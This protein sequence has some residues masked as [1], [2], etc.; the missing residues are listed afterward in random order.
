LQIVRDWVLRFNAKGPH[1]LFN[2]KAPGAPSILHDSQRDAVRQ[3][4]EDGP[5]KS[6]LGEFEQGDKWSF[7]LKAAR[8]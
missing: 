1:G 5:G 2:A 6:W 7:C 8:V 3:I 4:L